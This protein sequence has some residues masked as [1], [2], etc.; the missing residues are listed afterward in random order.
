MNLDFETYSAAGTYYDLET[1]KFF[2]ANLETGGTKRGITLVGAYAY[3]EHHSTEVLVAR[4]SDDDG[5]TVWQWVPHMDPPP[6]DL[7]N[8]VSQGGIITA[9]NSF[10]EWCIW[11][12]VCVRLYGWPPLPIEQTRDTM[13]KALAW[14]LPG[15]LAKSSAVISGATQKDMEGN[16]IMR[17]LSQPRNPTKNDP[18][19]RYERHAPKNAK[20]ATEWDRL[21]SYCGDDVLAEIGVDKALPDLTPSELEVWLLDQ[22]INARGVLIDRPLV[23]SSLKIM[24]E[25]RTRAG[26][27]LAH[28]TGGAITA[29]SQATSILKWVNSQ[30]PELY[31]KSLEVPV[32]QEYLDTH[33]LPDLVV[34]V[35]EIR[36]DVG[37][38]APA[39]LVAMKYQAASDGRVRGILQYCG[40]QRTRRWAG[41]GIQTQNMP[42]GGPSM[43]ECPSCGGVHLETDGPECPCDSP[44]TPIEWGIDLI[45]KAVPSLQTGDYD[46]VAAQWGNPAKAVSGCLRSMLIAAPGYEYISSDYSAIEAVVMACMAGEQWIVDVFNSDGKLYERTGAKITGEDVQVL[47]DHKATHG[48]HHPARKLGKVASLASQFQGARGAWLKFGAGKFLS[49]KEIDEGVKGWRAASPNIVYYWGSVEAAALSAVRNPGAQFP[50][51]QMDG[52]PTGV[53]FQQ[54]DRALYCILPGGDWLTY[55]DPSIKSKKKLSGDGWKILE[56]CEEVVENNDMGA[57]YE[58]ETLLYQRPGIFE[59]LRNSRFKVTATIRNALTEIFYTWADTLFYWGTQS[60]KWVEIDTYGGK[61][62]ENITQATARFILSHALVN[63]EKAGYPVVMHTHDEI[64]SE[65]P[66]GSGSIEEYERIMSIMPTWAADWPIKAAGGW[67]GKRFRK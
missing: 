30:V 37:G 12:L 49:N 60:Y 36:R 43:R 19:L 9:Y 15:A 2:T 21:D 5:A 46:T 65:I 59:K 1:S 48:T 23:E 28:L 35:L 66:E 57:L 61:L 31:L 67:R 39:K 44:T 4:Y 25:S 3:A 22:K 58:V 7:L 13:A 14:S 10:F 16:R 47:F 38:N 45:E 52:A 29:V 33:T 50:V 34:K 24:K 63:V 11:N 40:A 41:R 18:R 6:T 26:I 17:K 53:T 64:V 62:A 42:N 56:L 8:Y 20:E 55:V 51:Y 27:E 32:L 54:V